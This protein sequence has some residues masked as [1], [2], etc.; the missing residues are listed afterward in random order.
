LFKN[1]KDLLV[2]VAPVIFGFD[3]LSDD[4]DGRQFSSGCQGNEAQ[5]DHLFPINLKKLTSSN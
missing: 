3:D 2:G 4:G 1:R 5:K